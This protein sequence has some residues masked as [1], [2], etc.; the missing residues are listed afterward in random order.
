MQHWILLLASLFVLSCGAA[1]E[2]ANS[3]SD[4]PP[5]AKVRKDCWQD[6]EAPSLLSVMQQKMQTQLEADL[7][8]DNYMQTFG[9][10]YEE[11]DIEQNAIQAVYRAILQSLRNRGVIARDDLLALLQSRPPRPDN[12][13]REFT[14]YVKFDAS[15]NGGHV[16]SYQIRI[17][18]LDVTHTIE[19]RL[20][21]WTRIAT[22]FQHRE[23]HFRALPK[24]DELSEFV[25]T[26]EQARMLLF[27]AERGRVDDI[28]NHLR[29][30][31]GNYPRQPRSLGELSFGDQLF[32]TSAESGKEQTA[33]F[34]GKGIML[35]SLPKKET[36][37]L[38]F[39]EERLYGLRIDMRR[40]TRLNAKFQ[41]FGYKAPETILQ[42]L[43]LKASRKKPRQIK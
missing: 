14:I 29:T 23:D 26:L 41:D 34:L 3:G 36:A 42:C 18:E 20:S 43:F 19:S 32:L 38:K 9:C 15:G 27:L 40:F 10:A 33:I 28:V 35:A 7:S 4:D 31:N 11:I 17:L 6:G 21:V 12:L 1:K 25:N 5:L 22:R 13:E 8:R 24:S 30:G 37:I 16:A 2:S 39:G